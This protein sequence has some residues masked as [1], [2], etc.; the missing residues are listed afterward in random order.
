MIDRE[1]LVEMV[2]LDQAVEELSQLVADLGGAERWVLDRLARG[3]SRLVHDDRRVVRD[4]LDKF[5]VEV[6]RVLRPTLH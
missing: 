4:T 3:L 6:R 5:F 2:S 1:A